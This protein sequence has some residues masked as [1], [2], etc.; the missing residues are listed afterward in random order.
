VITPMQKMLL[1]KY[2]DIFG[3]AYLEV[4]RDENG[5]I[6]RTIVKH[7]NKI[8]QF[9]KKGMKKIKRNA[10]KWSKIKYEYLP[11]LNKLKNI[12]HKFKKI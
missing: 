8:Y 1:D 3:E 7:P 9:T 11:P 10:K 12:P 5:K 6:I 4:I 2:M